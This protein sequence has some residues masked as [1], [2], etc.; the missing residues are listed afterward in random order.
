MEKKR[1]RRDLLNELSLEDSIVFENP[2]YDAA[3]IGYDES[4]GRIIYDF[5]KMAECLMDEDGMSY[6]DAIDFI[7]YNTLRALPYAG[8]DGPIV[9][10]G[11]EDY[12]NCGGE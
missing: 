2:D 3:I 1:P 7:S 4:S 5:E 12:L 8:A 6:E 11:I 10:R 9:M